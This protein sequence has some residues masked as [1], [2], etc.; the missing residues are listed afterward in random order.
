[1]H[2]LTVKD[3]GQFR[4]VGFALSAHNAMTAGCERAKLFRIP[5]A[6]ATAKIRKNRP[7]LL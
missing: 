6:V 5:S 3:S 4:A 2:V 1:M 7:G